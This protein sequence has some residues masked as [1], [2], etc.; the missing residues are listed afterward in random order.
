MSSSLLS[1]VK[2]PED[3]QLQKI[4][5]DEEELELQDSSVDLVT[6]SLRY[7]RALLRLE[8]RLNRRPGRGVNATFP[9]PEFFAMHAEL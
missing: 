1:A 9:P 6:S 3:M 8:V 7:R 2:S 4:N 5:S